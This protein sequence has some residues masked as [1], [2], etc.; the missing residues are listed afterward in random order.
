MKRF[1]KLAF[2]A[3]LVAGTAQADT[4][5]VYLTDLLDNI[6]DGYCLDIAKGKGADAN[7]EDGL[8]AHTCYSPLGSV[9]VDQGFDS[10]KFADGILHIVGFDVCVQAPSTEAG[11]AVE[12][13]ACDGSP[14]QN[15]V[16]DGEGTIAPAS[17]PDM[18]LT[19]GDETRLGRSKENQMRTLTLQACSEEAAALQTW[20]N[21]TAK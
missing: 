1:M 18:C 14:A 7:P 13:V 8:Q 21:R 16:F 12:L 5:E 2:A 11:A 3:T 4:V 20:D 9:L 15:W 6:Q 19:L 17:A 10:E